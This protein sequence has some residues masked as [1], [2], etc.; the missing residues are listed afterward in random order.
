M[1]SMILAHLAAPGSG[2]AHGLF[3]ECCIAAKCLHNSDIGKL[4]V[5]E[6]V[7]IGVTARICEVVDPEIKRQGVLQVHQPRRDFGRLCC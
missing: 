7:F 3:H 5:H 4:F 2:I 6:V 1:D